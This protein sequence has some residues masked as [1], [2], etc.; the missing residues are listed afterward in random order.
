MVRETSSTLWVTQGGL[1]AGQHPEAAI[2]NG[3]FL[4]LDLKP[5]LTARSM[6]LRA[7]RATASQRSR[8]P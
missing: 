2:V 3:F 1:M 6:I 8:S 5:D 4:C 7:F